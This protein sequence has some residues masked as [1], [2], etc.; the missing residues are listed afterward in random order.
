MFTDGLVRTAVQKVQG[1]ENMEYKDPLSRETKINYYSLKRKIYIKKVKTKSWQK[2][3]R[4]YQND[5]L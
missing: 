5:F 3:E 2:L 1:E 4:K